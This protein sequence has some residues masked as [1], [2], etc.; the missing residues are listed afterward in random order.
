VVR[1]GVVISLVD[2]NRRVILGGRTAVGSQYD[3]VVAGSLVGGWLTV[4]GWLVM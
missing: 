2:V 1:I 3:C 4:G